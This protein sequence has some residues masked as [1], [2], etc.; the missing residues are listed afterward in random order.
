MTVREKLKNLRCE[1]V[2]G[3]T[4]E[5]SRVRVGENLLVFT[6]GTWYFDGYG[7]QYL[8]EFYREYE[9]EDHPLVLLGCLAESEVGQYW[10][11]QGQFRQQADRTSAI[12]LYRVAVNKLDE[13]GITK[14]EAELK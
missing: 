1:N 2:D 12:Q 5:G 8:M 4:I 11:E 6:D 9:V 13:L 7:Q 10:K 14:E 3:K